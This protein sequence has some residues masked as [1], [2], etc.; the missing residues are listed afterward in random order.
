LWTVKEKLF[1]M[2]GVF[3]R[4]QAKQR[5]TRDSEAPSAMRRSK[6]LRVGLSRKLPLGEDVM[7]P[8]A[9]KKATPVLAYAKVRALCL[10]HPGTTE[11]D[12]WGHPNFRT[13]KR[14]FV[15]LETHQGHPSIAIR[16]VAEQ[17]QDLCAEGAFFPTPYG[18]GM[19]ASIYA[20]KRL[21]WRVMASL[22]GQ[23]Y[24]LAASGA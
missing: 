24:K 20:D 19:W 16:L 2:A 5:V 23:S 7:V 4:S 12:S 8:R 18:K 13:K 15:T 11:T 3:S 21:N 22:I 6:A 14:A 9:G 17:V 1:Y 10:S